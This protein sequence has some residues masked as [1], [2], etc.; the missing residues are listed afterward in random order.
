MAAV[1]GHGIL[2]YYS[3]DAA[4]LSNQPWVSILGVSNVN[5]TFNGET[6]DV[7]T[8]ADSG[9]MER[10][11]TSGLHSMSLSGD[12]VLDDSAD[13]LGIFNGLFLAARAPNAAADAGLGDF[14]LVVPGFGQWVAKFQVTAFTP[15]GNYN[16]A[17]R[18][19][20]TLESSGPI[21]YSATITDLNGV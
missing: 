13:G 6:V 11:P 7:T 3:A 5:P 1:D 4:D 9:C 10:K 16:D 17:G 21:T 8:N 18:L 2:V 12:G 14:R 20:F 15:G 19:S